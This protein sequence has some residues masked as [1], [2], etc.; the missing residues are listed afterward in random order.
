MALI[1]CIPSVEE[2]VGVIPS[3]ILIDTSDSLATVMASGYL[4]DASGVNFKNT[5]MALVNTTDG[6]IW[7]QVSVI[8]NTISLINGAKIA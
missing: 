6:L 4:N 8:G 5:Q 1:S 3:T 2:N 7:L